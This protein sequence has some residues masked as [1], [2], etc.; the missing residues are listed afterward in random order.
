MKPHWRIVILDS[1][2]SSRRGLKGTAMEMDLAYKR[3]F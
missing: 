1:L 3:V 2:D